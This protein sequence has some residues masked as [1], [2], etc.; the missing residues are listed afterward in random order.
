MFVTEAGLGQV[1]VTLG[2]ESAEVAVSGMI[3]EVAWDCVNVATTVSRM[4]PH[5]TLR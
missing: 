1:S 4:T 2:G 3:A 5:A